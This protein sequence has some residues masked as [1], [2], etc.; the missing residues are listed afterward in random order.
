MNNQ[1][2]EL[3]ALSEI[4]NIIQEGDVIFKKNPAVGS[5]EVSRLIDSAINKRQGDPR[6]HKFLEKKNTA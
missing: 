3:S 6:K 4:D 2:I 5:P 1:S